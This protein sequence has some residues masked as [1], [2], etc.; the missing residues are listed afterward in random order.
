M[1]PD[2][3]HRIS[4]V[5][6]YLGYSLLGHLAWEI[7]QLPLY[8]I[9]WDAPAGETAFAVLHCTAGDLLIAA[10]TLALGYLVAGGARWPWFRAVYLRVAIVSV[11]LGVAYTVFSEWLNTAVRESWAY[12]PAMPLIPVLEVGLTPVLQW[13]VVPLMAFRLT[14]LRADLPRAPSDGVPR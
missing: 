7:G 13:L 2:K 1:S 10:S 14:A 11:V 4:V 9:F 8:T 5:H 12:M 6:E 3:A